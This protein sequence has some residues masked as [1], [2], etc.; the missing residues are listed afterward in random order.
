MSIP[1][2]IS[3]KQDHQNYHANEDD[4][5]ASFLDMLSQNFLQKSNLITD[6][7]IVKLLTLCQVAQKS[8]FCR[9]DYVNHYQQLENFLF[10]AVKGTPF[11]NELT[12][13]CD[14]YKYHLN[15]SLLETQ[16]Q[17]LHTNLLECCDLKVPEIVKE[18]RSLPKCQQELMQQV[19]IATKLWLLAPATNAVS[20]R[21]ASSVRRICTYL[22]TRSSQ[23]R[24]KNCMVLSVHKDE[25]DKL[26]LLDIANEFCRESDQ[27][28]GHFRRFHARDQRNNCK[29]RCIKSTQCYKSFYFIFIISSIFRA[30]NVEKKT[31]QF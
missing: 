18:F 26:N 21:S 7:S 24:F 3:Y 19:K 25:V 30:C 22:R 11:Q 14:F 28:I 5:P 9:G 4:R 15:K 23:G 20:E 16:L 10:K 12:A 6:K 1:K 13:V 2:L 8:A 29:E 27:R 31:K 17:I